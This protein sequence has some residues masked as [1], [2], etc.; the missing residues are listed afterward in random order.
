MI[1]IELSIMRKLLALLLSTWLT[2]LT[3][4]PS[5]AAPDA[6]GMCK[7][8]IRET[9]NPNA[10]KAV[11]DRI[12]MACVATFRIPSHQHDPERTCKEQARKLPADESLAFEYV[13][14]TAM[15]MA[16]GCAPHQ[17]DC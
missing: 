12:F 1:S 6:S 13:C 16:Y 4:L 8:A 5:L 3:A 9:L 15:L 14:Q 11:V 17:Q 10:P 2:S 7:A